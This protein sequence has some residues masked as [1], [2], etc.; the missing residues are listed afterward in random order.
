[1][2]LYQFVQTLLIWIPH[3]DLKCPAIV[4]EFGTKSLEIGYIEASNS[5]SYP[6]NAVVFEPSFQYLIEV[7][8][9]FAVD[10]LNVFAHSYVLSDF[11]IRFITIRSNS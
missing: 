11:A 7:G 4:E 8:V 2:D 10:Y 1:M 9:V 6:V 5:D 3:Q